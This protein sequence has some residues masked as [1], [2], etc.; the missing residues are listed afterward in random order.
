MPL[1]I[2]HP[3]SFPPFLFC[4]D[5]GVGYTCDTRHG[6][7]VVNSDDVGAGGDGHGDGSGG[8]FHA[9]LFGQVKNITDELL[10]GWTYEY[11]TIE[12]VESIK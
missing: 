8:A 3:S 10:A 11:R 6:T 2:L 9:V 1:F 12:C 5:N 4:P 7:D